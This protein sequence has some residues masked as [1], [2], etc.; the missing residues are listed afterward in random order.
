MRE[1]E[2]KRSTRR[3]YLDPPPPSLNP[4]R[5]KQKSTTQQKRGKWETRWESQ[6][7]ASVP[8]T[9]RRRNKGEV[10]EAFDQSAQENGKGERR[11]NK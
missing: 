4:G 8:S 9:L 3:Q 2:R 5:E 7:L 11:G 6:R 10:A 1:R